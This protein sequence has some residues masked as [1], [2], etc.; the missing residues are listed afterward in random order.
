MIVKAVGTDRIEGGKMHHFQPLSE[1]KAVV[2][3]VLPHG[4]V[5]RINQL[6][7]ERGMNRSA[8]N[9]A[10]LLSRRHNMQTL[11]RIALVDP[12]AASAQQTRLQRFAFLLLDSKVAGFRVITTADGQL[13]TSTEEILERIERQFHHELKHNHIRVIRVQRKK[14]A[15]VDELMGTADEGVRGN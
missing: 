8:L 13:E 4:W 1:G 15:Q 2:Q 6:A 7:T 3:L 9:I 12:D 10:F 14:R 11:L 5:I